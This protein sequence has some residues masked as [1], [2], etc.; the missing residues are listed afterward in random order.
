M[1]K[2]KL[3]KKT[4]KY[5]F[6]YKSESIFRKW[7]QEN[8]NR[9]NYKPMRNNHGGYYFEGITKAI[10]LSIEFSQPEAELHFNNP[11]NDE[12]YDLCSIQYIGHMKYHPL[13]GFYDADRVDKMF[14]Y[15]P[16]YDALIITEVFEPIIAYTQKYFKKENALYLLDNDKFTE[17]FI[18]SSLESELSIKRIT[19]LEKA[20]A[21]DNETTKLFK[22]D[23][24]L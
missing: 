15:Y 8:I 3:S 4:K 2:Y 23:V 7:L 5:K 11:I 18:S 24:V 6:F 14:T 10:S 13:H 12:N 9:F 17:G 16:T 1:K 21:T 22:Y 20:R 19:K